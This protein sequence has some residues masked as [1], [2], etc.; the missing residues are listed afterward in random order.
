MK[1]L[2]LKKKDKKVLIKTHKG[3][4]SMV[5]IEIMQIS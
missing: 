1:D 3:L 2:K 4:I 5:I